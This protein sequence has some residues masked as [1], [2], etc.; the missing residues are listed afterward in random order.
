MIQ[1]RRTYN[2]S[3]ANLWDATNKV[4]IGANRDVTELTTYG[5]D[6]TALDAL[7]AQNDAF[8]NLPTDI[9][10]SQEMAAATEEKN[11]KRTELTNYVLVE[12]MARVELKYGAD[13]KVY[14]QFGT[15]MIHNCS[16]AEFF[17]A[18]RRI[19]RKASSNLANL[20]SEGLLNSHLVAVATLIT[21]FDTLIE[22]QEQSIENRDAAVKVRVLAGNAQYAVLVKIANLGKRLWLSVDESKY[23]DYVLYPNQNTPPNAQVV[24][25]SVPAGTTVNLSLTDLETDMEATV[26][27]LT[28]QGLFV[29]FA[30]SPTDL[31]TNTTPGAD[32]W[33]AGNS[34]TSGS[35]SDAGYLPG[36]REYAN[37]YNPGPNPGSIRVTVV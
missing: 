18:V 16:D 20:A 4:L 30:A 34:S 24:E 36:V 2:F 25:T 3:D 8:S 29:Y 33:V 19:R 14:K 6:Q 10:L 12:I 7:N 37:A 1:E 13:S 23:N 22:A 17:F 31:P 26:E 27:T 35:L 5:I 11:A 21:D 28:A 15:G 32:G 9:E